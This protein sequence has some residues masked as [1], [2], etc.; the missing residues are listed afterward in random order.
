[1]LKAFFNEHPEAAIAF[2]GGADSAYL[3]Y[4]AKLY[5][6][7]FAAYYVKTAFQPEFE[8]ADAL[9]LARELDIPLRV[10]CLD[11]L[12][13]EEIASN[14]PD[15]CYHC[16]RR[17]FGAIAEAARREG[18]TLLLDGTNASDEEGDRPGMRALKELCVLSP[19]R[20][21]GLE[22][23]RVRELSREAGLFT[24]DKPAYACLA[25]RIACGRRIERR[26]LERTERA[27][28]LL[29]A[30]G[31]ADFRIRTLGETALLQVTGAQM[32]KAREEL[33]ELKRALCP[34][35]ADL[36]L[37]MEARNGQ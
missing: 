6:K 17:I 31:F 33:E 2:S 30:M 8:L 16:K 20:M 5:A 13:C 11:T 9:R 27:E 22:K 21:A 32:E 23:R 3:L 14:P 15:R 10:L 25:T 34:P 12:G 1:M 4:E 26:L 35:Y 36:L 24:W 18:F 28:G 29:S 7:R 19:L 37:D